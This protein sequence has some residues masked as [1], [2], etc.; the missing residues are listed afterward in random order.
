MPTKKTVDKED[1][2]LGMMDA[3]RVGLAIGMETVKNK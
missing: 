1:I 3:E 2:I